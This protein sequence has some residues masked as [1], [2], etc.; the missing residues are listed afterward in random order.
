MAGTGQE[1]RG[2]TREAALLETLGVRPADESLYLRL[3][4]LGRATVDRL[5]DER[6]DRDQVRRGLERLVGLGLASTLP[7][8][9]PEH[10]P[11]PPDVALG[12]LISEQ[13]RRLADARLAAQ[14]LAEQHRP[15]SPSDPVELIEVVTGRDA[16]AQRFR[17]LVRGASRTMLVFDTPPYANT[18]ES[19]E[20]LRALGRGVEWRAVYA[21]RAIDDGDRL[22]RVREL[23]DHGEQPRL[24]PEVPMKLAVA[25]HEV[26]LLPLSMEAAD[27]SAVVVRP[28][29]LL[30]ALASLFESLWRRALPIVGS[31]EAETGDD[32]EVVR[33]LAA[34]LTDDAIARRLAVSTRTVRR[35]VARL[36]DELDATSRFQA[37]VQAARR[38]WL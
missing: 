28:S 25:D 37:G 27:H 8:A 1:G 2:P 12:V 6:H 18:D 17:Q 11:T 5:V 21:S 35:R 26:A 34:G 24:L 23:A 22:D 3:L 32:R 7:Q 31:D 29:T 16:V 9:P 30:R 14:R 10:V 13:E 19:A 20:Q 33:M 36:A 38:G 15:A 4:E